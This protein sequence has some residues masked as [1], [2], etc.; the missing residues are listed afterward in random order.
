MY[1]A[2]GILV[3]DTVRV[4]SVIVS[5]RSVRMQSLAILSIRGIRLFV[6]D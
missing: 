6:I 2:R 5:P 1:R 4:V 3:R